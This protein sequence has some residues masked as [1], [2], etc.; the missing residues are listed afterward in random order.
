MAT[1]YTAG[2]VQGQKLTAAIMNQLGAVWEAW[3]PT[4]S[5][6]SGTFT[7]VTTNVARYARIQN[8]IIVRIDATVTT[9]GTASG[10]MQFTLPF[11]AQSSR[12]IG[13]MR[14]VAVI[15]HSGTIDL[16]TTTQ[17]AFI[18]YAAGNTAVGSYRNSGT[19]V[20]EAA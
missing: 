17:G 19:L 3:T 11:T 10:F 4:Y 15:G 6:S 9:L 12:A 18:L 1:Q 8:I 16:L 20:Y 14:E 7:T 5:A 2:L 13:V